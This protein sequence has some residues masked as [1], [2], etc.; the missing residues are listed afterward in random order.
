MPVPRVSILIPVFNGSDF[1]S[2]CLDS[3]LA[4]DFTDC[5]ILIS[6]DG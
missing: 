1:L 6:E 3:V 4:Q 5:E 2:A